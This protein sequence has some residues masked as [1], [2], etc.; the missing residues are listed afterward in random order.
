MTGK[1][2]FAKG[3]VAA[4]GIA[5]AIALSTPLARAANIITFDDN[6]NGC[7]GAVMCSTNGT[8]GY[9]N[10]GAGQAFDLS[11]IGSWFQIDADGLN[12]L[13]T[14]TTAE[15]D[16][17]A[18]GFLVVNDTGGT[19]KSFSLILTDTFTSATPSVT[20]CSGSSGPLCDVFQANKG[21]AAPSGASETLSGVNFFSCTSP[22]GAN[23]CTTSTAGNVAAKFEPGSVIFT[24]G[25]LN[26][27]NGQTFDISFASWNNSAFVSSVP[28]PSTWGLMILGFAGLGFAGYR[29]TRMNRLVAGTA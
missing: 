24:W 8:T 6:A 10:N 17:G 16:G 27:A 14:Q 15:P 13:A 3:V 11:T 28:E 12:H 7:G 22:S 26:I 29:Q 18:S 4:L 19:V 5:A 9:L 20:F 2:T 23:P 1:T 21:A 25:G